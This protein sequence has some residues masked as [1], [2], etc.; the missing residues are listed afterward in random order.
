[1]SFQDTDLLL[2]QNNNSTEKITFAQ[3]KE[4]TVLND[5]DLLLINNG[6]KTNKVTWGEIKTEI[7]PSDTAPEIGSVSLVESNPNSDPRFTNQEFVASVAMTEEGTPLSTKKIDA[8]VEGSITQQVQFDEPLVSSS[9]AQGPTWSGGTVQYL[10]TWQDGGNTDQSFNGNYSNSMASSQVPATTSE[11]QGAYWQSPQELTDVTE[12]F[13]YADDYV[14]NFFDCQFSV[15]G[16]TWTTVTPTTGDPNNNAYR[17]D[18]TSLIGGTTVNSI[19]CQMTSN[20]VS[21]QAPRWAT[22]IKVNGKELI[23]DDPTWGDTMLTFAAGTD[24][25]TLAAGDA[26]EQDSQSTAE[27]WSNGLSSPNTLLAAAQ[28]FDGNESTSATVSANYGKLTWNIGYDINGKT[29]KVKVNQNNKSFT[30]GFF[31]GGSEFARNVTSDAT[32]YLEY[33]TADL[34]V[35]D[36]ITQIYVQANDAFEPGV[37]AFY[38]DD[39]IVIDGQ[40]IATKTS[41]TVDSVDNTAKTVTLSSS[42]GTWTNGTNVTGPQKS[43]TTDNAKK[44]LD[45][46]SDGTV[47]DLLDSPQD[48][49]YTTD[50]TNPSLTFKFPATFPSGNAPD[51]ELGDGTKLVVEVTATNT[52]GSDGPKTAEVQPSSARTTG[53]RSLTQEEFTQQAAKFVTYNNRRDVHQGEQAMA[54]RE[55]LYKQLET[56]GVDPP[57]INKLLGGTS[58]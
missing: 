40:S 15:N 25:T 6:T 28:A 24:M 56:A 11:M 17:F 47:T 1:M 13:Y 7:G 46:D 20:G 22:V 14:G 32:A 51:D 38:L 37:N 2:V 49:S 10:G 43:I 27:T 39:E 45:F 8:Y 4:Q 3:L 50:G 19:G 30:L 52:A 12:L 41:G 21:F 36:P 42:N 29:L 33:N 53:I 34:Y 9:K 5:T 26:V 35:T 54:Q 31:S 58:S 55:A 16:G 48:P 57:A 18:L 23:D 44:Y